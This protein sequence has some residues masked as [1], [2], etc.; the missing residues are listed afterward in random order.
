MNKNRAELS[1]KAHPVSLKPVSWCL[2]FF[3]MNSRYRP[4]LILFASNR[5]TE[6]ILQT[7][8]FFLVAGQKISKDFLSPVYES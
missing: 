1:N 2:L 8:V 7:S 5:I 4:K 3:K 6:L